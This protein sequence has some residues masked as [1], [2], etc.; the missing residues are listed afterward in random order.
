MSDKDWVLCIDFAFAA[1]LAVLV[2]CILTIITNDEQ[3]SF[4]KLTVLPYRFILAYAFFAMIQYS[5]SRMD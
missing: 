5:L 3:K 2:V 1:L 4:N